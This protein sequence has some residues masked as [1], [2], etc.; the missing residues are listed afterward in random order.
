MTPHFKFR[1]T[2]HR[3]IKS[4]FACGIEKGVRQIGGEAG[5]GFYI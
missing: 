5:N 2:L 1:L 4:L 3:L